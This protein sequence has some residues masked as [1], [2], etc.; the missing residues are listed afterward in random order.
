[1]VKPFEL[2]ELAL[3]VRALLRR[4]NIE[5]DRKITVGNLVLNADARTAEKA[6]IPSSMGD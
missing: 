6:H 3:R 1:M 2:D 5:T 4:A